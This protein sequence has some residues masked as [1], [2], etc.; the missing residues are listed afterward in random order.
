MLEGSFFFLTEGVL[1]VKR[2]AKCFVRNFGSILGADTFLD[3]LLTWTT[4]KC[5]C[6]PFVLVKYTARF[7]TPAFNIA[8]CW[9]WKDQRKLLKLLCSMCWWQTFICP[10]FQASVYLMLLPDI[11]WWLFALLL[12]QKRRT[13]AQLRQQEAEAIAQENY[14]QGVLWWLLGLPEPCWF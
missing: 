10:H 14:Q 11:I 6:F 9:S 4:C 12:I 8:Q 1:E 2:K 13:V 3:T 7:A 5:L